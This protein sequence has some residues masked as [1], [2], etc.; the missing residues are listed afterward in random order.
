MK[1]KR[2]SSLFHHHCVIN[3]KGREK[4]VIDFMIDDDTLL[5]SLIKEK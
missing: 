4:L 1:I 2:K 5:Y 3:E